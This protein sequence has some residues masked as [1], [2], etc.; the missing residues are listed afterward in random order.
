MT[1]S[2]VSNDHTLIIRPTDSGDYGEYECEA[3]NAEGE[4]QTARAFLNVHCK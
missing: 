3:L 1:R 2:F 4:R